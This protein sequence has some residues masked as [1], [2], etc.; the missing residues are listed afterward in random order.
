M[1]YHRYERT[2]PK[3]CQFWLEVPRGG[4]ELQMTVEKHCG[5]KYENKALSFREATTIESDSVRES[6]AVH[7]IV[8][9]LPPQMVSERRLSRKFEI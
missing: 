8:D 6:P 2:R 7:Y 4:K 1:L 3:A 5:K 9:T